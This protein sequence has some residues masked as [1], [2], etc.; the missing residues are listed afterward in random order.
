MKILF[1]LG[2]VTVLLILILQGCTYD[3]EV[4][5]SQTSCTDTSH[6]SYSGKVQPILKT[7]CFGCH[8]NGSRE[9]N[10]SLEI[11][12]DVKA[13]AI[14][15]KLLGSISH[16]AGFEPMPIGADKLDDCSIKAIKKWIE[17]GC[18]NN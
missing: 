16:T 11:Y 7:N 4:Y 2:F 3:K 10:I 13:M 18:Q 14:G 8:G 6:I 12:D 9:G 5:V 15:G 17:E 1:L